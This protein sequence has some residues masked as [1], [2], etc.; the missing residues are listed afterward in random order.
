M[1]DET[2]ARNYAET[3]F[4]LAVKRDS[5]ETFQDGIS[6]VAQ[7]ISENPGVREFLE[8]PRIAASEKKAVLKKAL[9]G[10]IPPLLANFLNVVIDKRRQRLIG[11]IASQFESL[12]DEKVGRTHVDVTVARAM[13]DGAVADLT[14][15]LSRALGKT[16]VPH[17]RVRPEIVGGIIVQEGDTIYDGSVRRQVEGMRRRLLAAQLPAAGV[18]GTDPAQT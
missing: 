3:L 1:R 12:V 18:S 16:V 9:S 7:L 10:S 6:A 4:E 14:A 2:V 5:V 17:V 11:E 8:T 13:D 15:R